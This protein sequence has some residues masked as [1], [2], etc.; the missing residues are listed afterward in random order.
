MYAVDGPDEVLKFDGVPGHTP[1]APEPLVLATA[2]DLILAYVTAPD[3]DQYAIVKFLCPRAHYF[4]SPNDEALSGHPL[5]ARGLGPYGIFEIRGSS[6]VRSLE[7]MNRV[8]PRHDASRFERL[9]H[10][11]FTFH[12]DTFECVAEGME[13]MES[14]PNE[15]P[16]SHILRVISGHLR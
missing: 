8:H 10:F 3:D 12:D 7:Q 16:A 1:G 5:A 6:W 9:R 11:V 15:F 4:G 13:L 2:F 14:V